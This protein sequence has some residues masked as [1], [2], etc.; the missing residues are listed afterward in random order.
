[1]SFR[2]IEHALVAVL[3][4]HAVGMSFRDLGFGLVLAAICHLLLQKEVD[5]PR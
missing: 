5:R 2:R 4:V 3:G 1:M